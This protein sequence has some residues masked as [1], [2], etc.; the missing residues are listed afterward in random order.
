MPTVP[1]VPQQVRHPTGPASA[2]APHP[3]SRLGN[4]PLGSEGGWVLLAALQRGTS[5]QAGGSG[6]SNEDLGPGRRDHS[7]ARWSEQTHTVPSPPQIPSHTQHSFLGGRGN[8]PSGHYPGECGLA[9]NS[10]AGRRQLSGRRKRRCWA[11][12][13]GRLLAHSLDARSDRGPIHSPTVFS[14]A[15]LR[16]RGRV[17]GVELTF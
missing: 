15:E 16:E 2:Q 8:R 3:L 7:G 11:L 1:A 6:T 9:S 17:R 5:S 12:A 10:S 4:C 13:D 14:E